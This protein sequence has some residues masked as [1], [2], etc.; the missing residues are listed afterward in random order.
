MSKKS[1]TLFGIIV[2]LL[3]GLV[4]LFTHPDFFAGK[5]SVSPTTEQERI[6]KTIES[7]LYKREKRAFLSTPPSK[8]ICKARI[9]W[10]QEITTEEKVVYAA[11]V[12]LSMIALPTEHDVEEESGIGLN[13]RLFKLARIG[14]KWI[15]V[16]S[17]KRMFAF[18]EANKDW[19]IKAVSMLPENIRDEIEEHNNIYEEI[20]DDAKKHFYPNE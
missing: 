17:D 8:F 20:E 9:V 15:I 11:N 5:D 18:E 19:I 10:E 12:C 16:D 1:L 7:Y 13:G 2:V 14:T 6:E 3:I 4:F